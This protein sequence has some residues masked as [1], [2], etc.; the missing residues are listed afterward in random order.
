MSFGSQTFLVNAT[1]DLYQDGSDVAALPNGGFA[2]VWTGETAG[3][4]QKDIYLQVFDAFA[5]RIGSEALVNTTTDGTQENPEIAAG[6]E[7]EIL[8]FWQDYNSIGLPNASYRLGDLSGS[9]LTGEILLGDSDRD[10]TSVGAVTSVSD[11]RFVLSYGTQDSGTYYAD[12]ARISLVDGTGVE[13]VDNLRVDTSGHTSGPVTS[14]TLLSGNVVVIWRVY[15]GTE[16]GEPY[17]TRA[18][19]VEPNGSPVG[20]EFII[21]EASSYDKLVNVAALPDGRFVVVWADAS[22]SLDDKYGSAVYASIWN[23]DGTPASDTILVNT[24]TTGDQYSPDI[25]AMS[26]GRFLVAWSD[27]YYTDDMDIRGQ[28][29]AADGSKIGGELTLSEVSEGSKHYPS[30]ATLADGRVAVSWSDYSHA[31][32]DTSVSAVVARLLDFRTGP[33][34]ISGSDLDDSFVGTAFADKI[35]GGLGDDFLLGQDGDD[36]LFGGDGSDK[37]VGGRGDDTAAGD[38]GADLF[39]YFVGDDTMTITDFEPGIDVLALGG[40]AA[41]FTIE[42]LVPFVCQEG[43]DVMIRSG[44]QE[45]RFEDTRLSDLSADDVRFLLLGDELPDTLQGSGRA[46]AIFG[47]DGDDDLRGEGG[48]DQLFGGSGDDLLDGWTGNDLLNG[49]SGDDVL[50]GFAGNDVLNGG[51]GD[52]LL[53]GEEGDDTLIGGDG[54]DWLEGGTGHDEVTG[55]EG[56]DI[57]VFIVGD[58]TM[59][60]TDFQPGVD[61]LALGGVGDGF[62]VADLLPYVSQEGGDV[63][64]RSG[65][66]EVRLEDTLLSD[67][68]A[69]DVF[70]V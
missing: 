31:F 25:S 37:L 17:Q 44:T 5:W 14:A 27:G 22:G 3:D 1:T 46:E 12:G 34:D 36:K 60:I 9:P 54:R 70:F 28:V 4:A 15:D 33:V 10:L 63:V 8:I 29:F 26:D 6:D 62:T 39:V 38:G 45:V 24:T 11:G 67:L 51:V 61:L 7:G 20:D 23:E 18:Q 42:D 56:S 32:G 47:F 35:S 55:D 30:L 64:I 16:Q 41:D 50:L 2:I 13:I 43:D 57:F 66:Q 59:T 65:T 58:D 40:L 48:N 53:F 52:D 21:H 49:E 69:S 68:S 19:V